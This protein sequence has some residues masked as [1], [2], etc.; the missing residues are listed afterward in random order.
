M[1]ASLAYAQK[2]QRCVCCRVRTISENFI[3]AAK[4]M[5]SLEEIK[6]KIPV[7]GD[8]T[9]EVAVTHEA[10][11]DADVLRRIGQLVM[12]SWRYVVPVLAPGTIVPSWSPA[13]RD[14]LRIR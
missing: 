8:I 5:Q 1:E 12:T 7:E 2:H 10:R 9:E 11:L 14:K 3:A 13:S 4:Q 6:F